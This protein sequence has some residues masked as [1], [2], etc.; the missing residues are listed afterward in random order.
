ML[1]DFQSR[2]DGTLSLVGC[3]TVDERQRFSIELP[4]LRYAAG[5]AGRQVWASGPEAAESQFE[6]DAYFLGSEYGL[7]V[8]GF[9]SETISTAQQANWAQ[10][11]SEKV[12]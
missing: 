10:K 8:G 3:E 2:V 1:L 7:K 6:Y 5:Y 12:L 9:A 4:A 11:M